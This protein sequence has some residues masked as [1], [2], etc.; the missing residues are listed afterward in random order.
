M[1]ARKD[2][3]CICIF[4]SGPIVIGQAAEF[5]YSGVQAVKAL[6][7]D[8]YRVVLVNSNPAT[9]MTDPDLADATYIEPLT[10]DVVERV[11]EMENP[12]AVL[13]TVGGQTALNLAMDLHKRGT[14]ERLNIELIG[15]DPDVID[16]AENRE[17]FKNAMDDIGLGS[18]RSLVCHNLDDVKR[19]KEMFGL[20]LVIR[21]SFTMGGSGGG[22]A[23]DDD[24]LEEICAHGLE[25]SPTTELLV[26]ESLLGWKEY[27]L[28]LMRDKNDNVVVVCSIENLDPMGIHT[29]DSVTIAPAQT[30]S[31]REYQTL[32]D[33]G[34]AVLREIG[35]ET[36]GSNVQFA[37]NPEDGRLIVIEMNP[38]VSRSSALASKATGF[39]IAKVA[40][41]LAV[42]YTLDEVVND[43]T[44]K[45][46]AAF[47]P[48]L[49]YV[50]TKMPRFAFEKFKNTKPI[51]S[52]QMKSVGEAMAIGRTFQESFGKA[53]RSLELGLMGL[54][55]EGIDKAAGRTVVKTRKWS[56]AEL[57]ELAA[58]PV[59]ERLWIL[60]EAMR[61]GASVEELFEVSAVDPFFL[62]H[63]EC[64]VR[65]EEELEKRGGVDKLDEKILWRAKESGISDA[66]IAELLSARPDFV[67]ARRKSLG[68]VPSMKRVDTCA[69]E[70]EAL[71]PYLYSS[72]ERPF[73]RLSEHDG[74]LVEEKVR[75]CEAR[76]TQNK[77]VLILG[78]GPIRIGQGIEFDYCCVHAALALSESGIESI[79]VNCNPETVSTDYDTADRLYFEPLTLEDVLNIVDVEHP[80]G[81]IVQFGGQTP[82]KLAKGLLDA[83]VHILG[84][85]PDAIDR[86]EDRKRST[87]LVEKL[88]LLQPEGATATSTEE[89]R[90]AAENLGFP[91][92]IRPSY[93]LG[94]RAMETVHDDNG[95][96]H[97]LETATQASEDKPVLIDR[98]LDGA[99]EV[100]VDVLCD[101]ERAVVAGVMQH[102][103]EAGVHSGDSACVLPPH[104]LPHD[105]VKEIEAASIALALELGV[106]GLMNAQFG[107]QRGKVYVI[108]VN[109]RASRTV[110]F[111]S[112]ATGYALA[113]LATRVMAGKSLDDLGVK[114]VDVTTNRGYVAVKEAVLPFLKFAGEDILL[115]PEMRSTGEVMGIDT[116]VPAAFAKSQLAAGT[117]L[118]QGGC[119]F[120]SVANRDKNA[121]LPLIRKLNGL[122]FKVLATHGTKAFL[123]DNGIKASG[124]NKVYEGSPHVVDAMVQ[125]EVQMVVNTTVGAK[126]VQDSFSLRRQ[127]LQDGIP[128]FTTLAG[129]DAAADAIEALRS[130][131][132]TPMKLQATLPARLPSS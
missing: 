83:G 19:A 127:A 119:V 2:L 84:T 11:L 128:Y 131:A 99:I 36:G 53:L 94:G 51:L 91:V 80:F 76:P 73:S 104:S 123:D 111:V 95:L 12:C 5:D 79:M 129:A 31:D 124:I 54:A 90:L 41:K 47:E 17:R 92:M 30:L 112:K 57:L 86:A 42:G 50:V 88:N 13:P 29:G 75:S 59:P 126:A 58:S 20:P 34:I 35:V 3:K 37:V 101:G 115:G 65:L 103:E 117:D 38:R 32:R 10:P 74:A 100:D 49:D 63:L 69:G 93:V 26:E 116:S 61:Q 1:P 24:E 7:A 45:T 33:A 40:A 108:E 97:Y 21:P 78:S 87:A 23:F 15:A 39:P 14:F 125:G 113:S 109:P 64:I 81:V 106:V 48:S 71:T 96:L 118:P 16:K 130:G 66:R 6:K 55:S 56:K 110:P 25:L 114:A 44:Q 70:F 22:I 89:A 107:V 18:A 46:K 9:I 121:A 102:I 67:R 82:L 85:S 132:G 4:G 72:Y 27:E 28:E 122:G 8:G 60:A 62:T 43:I 105:V 77:K 52:T 98:F 120:V 68:V